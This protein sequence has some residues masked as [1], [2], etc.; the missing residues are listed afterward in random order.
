[1]MG[2]GVVK[3]LLNMEKRSKKIPNIKN[4]DA[5]W[6]KEMGGKSFVITCG[7]IETLYCT[8]HTILDVKCSLYSEHYT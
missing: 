8:G 4:Q 1:M 5:K 3:K 2:G 7:V 6:N